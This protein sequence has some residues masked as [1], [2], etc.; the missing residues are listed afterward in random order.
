MSLP[1]IKHPLY[2]TTLPVSGKTVEYRSFT[3]KEEKILLISKESGDMKS[4]L[5]GMKQIVGNCVNNVDVDS[6]PL[7]DIEYVLLCIRARSVDNK[8]KFTIKDPDTKEN[9][10]LELDFDA[11]QVERSEDHSDFIKVDDEISIKMRYPAWRE[12]SEIFE[13]QSRND[14]QKLLEVM[15]ECI[16]KVFYND[17]IINFSEQSEEEVQEFVDDMTSDTIKEIERFFDTA[18]RLRHVMKYK[19]NTGKDKTFV[20]EGLKTFFI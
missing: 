4:I 11:V 14:K 17:Q 1:K 9:V 18:P 7:I 8:T 12:M 10:E 20:I 2:S 6:L 5:L 13:M 16:D 19:D 3:G 15:L